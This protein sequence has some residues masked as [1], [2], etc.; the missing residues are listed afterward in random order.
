MASSA[1]ADFT[2][3]TGPQAV[4]PKLSV[5]AVKPANTALKALFFN[6]FVKVLLIISFS[7]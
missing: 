1:K 3:S 4:S 5:V 6:A 7:F 2:C